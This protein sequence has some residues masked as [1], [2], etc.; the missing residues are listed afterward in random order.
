MTGRAMEMPTAAYILRAPS[1]AKIV[2][3]PRNNSIKR[4]RHNKGQLII[5]AKVVSKYSIKGAPIIGMR[6]GDRISTGSIGNYTG[7]RERHRR[8]MS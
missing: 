8:I 1:T 2:R 6:V 3:L 5:K 4:A 7:I